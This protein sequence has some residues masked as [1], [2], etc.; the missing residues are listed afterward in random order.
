MDK[1]TENMLKE[2]IFPLLVN[3]SAPNTIA[4][5]VQAV[6]VLTEVWLIGRLGTSALAAVALAFPV[7]MLTQQMAFGA[8]GGAVSS[9]LARS[10]GAGDKQRAEEL[11]WHALFLAACGALF[12]LSVFYISGELLL[13]ILGG[14]G[15]LLEQAIAYCRVFLLGAIVIWLSGTLSAALRGIG[16]MRFPALLIIFGSGLQVT[17]AGGLI[18]GWFGLPR[19][20]I[21]GAPL[22]AILSGIFMSSA[23]LIKLSYF[24]Q[25]V[26]LTLKRLSLKKDLF[27]DIF[28][29]AL[30]ASLSPIF[31]VATILVLTAFVGQ[32][33]ASALAGY[34][35][36]SRIEFLMIPLVFGIGTAMTTM[37][38][39]NMGAKNIHRA[40]RIGW[41][42]GSLA[43]FFSGI[44]GLL[45]AISADYWINFFTTDESAY[46]ATKAYIQIVGLCF[47]FQGLGLSLYFASQGAN[48]MKWPMIATGSRF[49]LASLGGW[50][51]IN[52]FSIGLNGVFYSAALAMTLYGLI[53]VISLK[54][55]AWRKN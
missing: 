12:F 34:G 4:F 41:L 51:A 11:L 54:L 19:L 39:T 15:E 32:F 46:E 6:V 49:I 48:A 18:L 5:L 16:N 14:K 21:I 1:R 28:S 40:E 17:L 24:S 43:G 3:M 42:G 22:A 38:G 10:L 23:M 20:G 44:I 31:T 29:V 26:E 8:L 36:G 52:Y 25:E 13:Q 45:L 2:P 30:P 7:I 37:V 50:L 53:L 9:S 35:I 47:T 55:G 27:E 33:G